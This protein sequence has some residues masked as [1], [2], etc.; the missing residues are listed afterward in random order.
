MYFTDSENNLIVKFYNYHSY[1]Q[2]CKIFKFY[3]IEILNNNFKLKIIFSLKKFNLITDIKDKCLFNQILVSFL[4]CLK[5]CNTKILDIDINQLLIIQ[6]TYSLK[7][8]ILGL[9]LGYLYN[10]LTNNICK[11]SSTF[12]NTV[13]GDLK[14]LFFF[15][16]VNEGLFKELESFFYNNNLSIL[17]IDKANINK[18]PIYRIN[19]CNNYLNSIFQFLNTNKNFLTNVDLIC[20]YKEKFYNNVFNEIFMKKFNQFK[21]LGDK[22]NKNILSNNKYLKILKKL[23]NIKKNENLILSLIYQ[24]YNQIIISTVFLKKILYLIED[25]IDIEEL[26]IIMDYNKNL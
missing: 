5:K 17:S 4:D 25:N 8:I 15:E 3:N 13:C 19:K 22:F 6:N 24:D 21:I 14:Y 9:N 1:I 23:A 12:S 11:I 10:N 16:N 18:Y 7:Y 20:I 26:S 2:Y